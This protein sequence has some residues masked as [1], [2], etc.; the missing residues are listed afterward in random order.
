M[1]RIGSWQHPGPSPAHHCTLRFLHTSCPH[2]TGQHQWSS[3]K[4]ACVCHFD[5]F[6]T[7]FFSWLNFGWAFSTAHISDCQLWI[8]AVCL[9][10]RLSYCFHW[11]QRTISLHLISL[12]VPEAKF[13]RCKAIFRSLPIFLWRD[14]FPKALEGAKFY[15]LSSH[16][17]RTKRTQQ[18]EGQGAKMI[19]AAASVASVSSHWEMGTTCCHTSGALRSTVHKHTAHIQILHTHNHTP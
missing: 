11:K 19:Q 10:P 4:I 8:S 3:N 7:S 18:G 6:S 17:I 5:I 15:L 2:P 9:L 13:N 16:G 1:N 14:E 12:I